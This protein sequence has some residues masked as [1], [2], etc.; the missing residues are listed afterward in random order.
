MQASLAVDAITT[1]RSQGH[2][3]L[4]N[5]VHLMPE[6]LPS[7]VKLLDSLNALPSLPHKDFRLI[8][9]S[10]PSNQVCMVEGGDPEGG[11]D[12]GLLKW[13]ARV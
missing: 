5:N 11:G 9:S 4:L 13:H 8:M 6:W 3:V 7:L 2:W 1:A 12:H 10:E